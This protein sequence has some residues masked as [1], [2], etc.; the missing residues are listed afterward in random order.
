MTFTLTSPAFRPGEKIPAKYTCD[1]K[2]TSIPL[3][4]TDAPNNTKS[5]ALINDDPDCS[6]GPFVHWLIYNIPGHRKDLPENFPLDSDLPDGTLQGLNDFSKIGYG[7]PCPPSGTHRYFFTLY[8]LDQV[9]SL[10]SKMQRK[11]L[12]LAIQTHVLGRAQ[13]MGTYQR[14]KK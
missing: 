9:L 6:G 7:G 3:A 14:Q 5:F 2:N 12:D 11:D 10:H 1:G 13:L 4:W 8:A